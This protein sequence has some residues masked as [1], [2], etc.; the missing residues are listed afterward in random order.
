M[1]QLRNIAKIGSAQNFI[2]IQNEIPFLICNSIVLH[3]ISF[4]GDPISI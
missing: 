1:M 3:M 4:L 2:L